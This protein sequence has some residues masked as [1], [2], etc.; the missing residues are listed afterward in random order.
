MPTVARVISNLTGAT[1]L[2]GQTATYFEIGGTTPT[3]PECT[4]IAA[5]VRALWNAMGTYLAVGVTV[6]VS[7]TCEAF[8]VGTGALTGT[9]TGTSPAGVV[10]SGTDTLP[11]ATMMG[12]QFRTSLPLNRRLLQGRMFIGPVGTNTQTAQ[13]LPSSASKTAL[14]AAGALLATGSSGATHV[15]WHRPGPSLS[16]GLASA[17]VTYTAATKYWILRSRRD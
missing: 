8:D 11:P 4:D 3:A 6:L 7:G 5:R 1:G 9:N 10:G 2:P 17:V 16:G 12:L 13:G 15:V 14:A